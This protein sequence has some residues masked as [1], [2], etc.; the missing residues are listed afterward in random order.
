[1]NY[2]VLS[3]IFDKNKLNYKQDFFTPDIQNKISKLTNISFENTYLNAIKWDNN[4]KSK[5]KTMI[6]GV[7][8][9]SNVYSSIVEHKFFE[10]MSY[11]SDDDFFI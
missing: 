4:L 3:A 2:H 11:N 5:L 7:R 1:M 10:E 8:N 9:N 6:D